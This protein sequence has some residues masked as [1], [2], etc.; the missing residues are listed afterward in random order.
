MSA[1]ALALELG[2]DEPGG[3]GVDFV[4]PAHVAGV[5]G[6]GA[7]RHGQRQHAAHALEGVGSEVGVGRLVG[8]GEFPKER[9]H[10]AGAGVRLGF[11]VGGV[12]RGADGPA[13][14]R[15]VRGVGG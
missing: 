7:Q 15:R 9:V 10:G 6:G 3:A 12:E 4:A 5:V 1:G 13:R 8:A 14:P 11:G 2:E